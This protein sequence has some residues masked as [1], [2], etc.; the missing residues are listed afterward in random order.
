M[1]SLIDA[2]I[3]DR[4]AEY[5]G[6][7]MENLM[8]NAGKAV[9]ETVLSLNP[10]R[11]LVVCGSG[12]N[13]GDGYTAA[14]Y[15]KR[16]GINVDVYPVKAPKSAL[17]MKK[18][19]EA[20]KEGVSIVN[21]LDPLQ[22]D[23]IIDAMLGIGI[24]R[25]PDEPYRSA[26]ERI[27]G[28]GKKVVSI[29]I[30][31]GLGTNIQVK[32]AITVTMQFM[33]KEMNEK[34]SGKIIVADVGFP[35][36]II[37]MVGPGEFLIYRF[38]RPDSHKGEN[39]ILAG[40][41]GS[42]D[43]YGAPLYM[44]KGALRMGIDLLFLFSP[45]SIH[46]HISASTHDIILRK[47]GEN[48]IEFNDD[49][50]RVIE[51]KATAVALGCGIG[52]NESSMEASLKIIEE[53]L[54]KGKPMVIDADA[55]DNVKN[56]NDFKGLAVIT[57]HRGE[58]KRIFSMEPEEENVMRMAKKYNLIILLKGSVD[59]ISDGEL[60]K[61]NFTFHHPSMTRGGTG[62]VLTGAVGGLLSRGIDPFHSATLA[63]FIVG[64]A[65]KL[66]FDEFSNAYFTS[67]MID[68]IPHVFKKFSQ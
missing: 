44:A 31:T 20:L 49:L 5:S 59:I 28:S 29:D 68:M 6:I 22:Y 61:K 25:D 47:S 33:K 64:S 66:A 17:C 2:R 13:G 21:S 58:F 3:L 26:I 39:G 1:Y 15:L 42:V 56:F 63:S 57:P 53:S 4:N 45:Y 24:E 60:V 34:N 19:E 46:H 10:E 65:G 9:A 38:N 40:I 55:L 27:N 11:V 62:D 18:S 14:I 41:A 37:E 67:E 7:N 30:P 35:R 16:K 52:K 12:N 32:P 43:Y 48:Y 50:M 51:E 8:E 36:D 54:K 23:I